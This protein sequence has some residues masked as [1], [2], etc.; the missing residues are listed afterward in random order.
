L[1]NC[2]MYSI[3]ST[4]LLPYRRPYNT[5]PGASKRFLD[6]G[7]GFAGTN[8]YYIVEIGQTQINS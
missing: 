6:L 3:Y 2:A 4:A 7:T 5:R 1:K 8:T